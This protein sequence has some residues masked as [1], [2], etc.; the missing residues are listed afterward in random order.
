M[1]IFGPTDRPNE[2]ITAGANI[3]NNAMV[4]SPEHVLRILYSAYPHPTIAR[5]FNLDMNG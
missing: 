5:M 1:G 2:P 3:G 4:D